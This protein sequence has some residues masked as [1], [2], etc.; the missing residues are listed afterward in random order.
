MFFRI[1]LLTVP[2]GT[3]YVQDEKD[4]NMKRVLLLSAPVGSGHKMAAEALEQELKTRDEI[5]VIHGNIFDFLPAWV[6]NTFLLWYMK[7]LRFCPWLYGFAYSSG[8]SGK[9]NFLWVR[10]WFNSYMLKRGQAFL[11]EYRPNIV[12]AT[13]ATPLGIMSLYKKAHPDISLYAVVPDYNIHHW[14]V[15]DGVDGYF[16]ADESLKKRFPSSSRVISLGLPLRRDFAVC[17]REECRKKHNIKPIEKVLLLMGG[18]DGLLP[19]EQLL[20]IF[21]EKHINNLRI[22]AIAGHNAD[23]VDKL[24]NT[25]VNNKEVDIY[26]FSNDIPEL[27]CA[28][29]IIVTKAGAV[30]A[31]EVLVSELAYIIYKPLPGQEE[32]NAKFLAKEHGAMIAHNVNELVRFVEKPNFLRQNKQLSVEKRKLATKHICD[33]ILQENN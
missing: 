22:I 33:M 20:E 21:T 18:G 2:D 24:Q 5:E 11:E 25:Y 7:L 23:L 32:G 8:D 14:W 6:G 19:M 16:I 15:C 13:H 28:A 17:E 1:S 9:G 29:D 30:T 31:A 4:E 3:V 12:I 26:G 10:N 27:M